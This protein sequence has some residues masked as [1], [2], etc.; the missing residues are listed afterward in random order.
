MLTGPV[1]EG[2]QALSNKTLILPT[3]TVNYKIKWILSNFCDVSKF[4]RSA[5]K[6]YEGL[7]FKNPL[8]Q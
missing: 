3:Y 1:D 7:N 2:E 5:S 8:R 4:K 6:K